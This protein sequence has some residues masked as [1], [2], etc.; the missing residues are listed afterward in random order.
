[1][2]RSRGSWSHGVSG[3][4]PVMGAGVFQSSKSSSLLLWWHPLNS[5]SFCLSVKFKSYAESGMRQRGPGAANHHRQKS[6][7]WVCLCAESIYPAQM[8]EVR[9]PDRQLS[10]CHEKDSWIDFSPPTSAQNRVLH[11]KLSMEGECWKITIGSGTSKMLDDWRVTRTILVWLFSRLS[12]SQH[13]SFLEP[14]FKMALERVD[15]GFM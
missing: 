11:S 5:R 3:L 10:I 1:M 7:R 6:S 4:D 2:R 12:P 15:S 14:V 13:E 9:L 8:G